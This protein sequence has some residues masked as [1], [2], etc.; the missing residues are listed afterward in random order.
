LL[1]P[2]FPGAEQNQIAYDRFA[3]ANLNDA[4]QMISDTSLYRPIAPAF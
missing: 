4:S 3:A 1:L 2:I